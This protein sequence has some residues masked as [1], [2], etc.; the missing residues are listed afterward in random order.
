MWL[1][2][3]RIWL[4]FGQCGPDVWPLIWAESWLAFGRAHLS[5]SVE[6]VPTSA[7][8]GQIQS[9]LGEADPAEPVPIARFLENPLAHDHAKAISTIAPMALARAPWAVEVDAFRAE[10]SAAAVKAFHVDA[11]RLLEADPALE[12]AADWAE[13]S[14][15]RS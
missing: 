2:F 5:T 3:D 12:A 15:C 13:A 10:P 14:A 8:L 1:V 4:D 6:S 11:R 9:K 7:D